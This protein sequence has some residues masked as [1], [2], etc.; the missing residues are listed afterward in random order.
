MRTITTSF[1]VYE[2]GELSK[3][4][5]RQASYSVS[6]EVLF[7]WE[8]EVYATA[9]ALVAHFHS[10]MYLDGVDFFQ[11][12]HYCLT[13]ESP[14]F[15]EEELAER[16]KALGSVDEDT[17]RGRGDCV[18]T[19]VCYD[20][21]VADVVRTGYNSGERDVEF[22]LRTAIHSL[23]KQA[24]EECESFYNNEEGVLQEFCDA[25]N[26]EFRESGQLYG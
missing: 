23:I 7:M 20:E 19:G 10:T 25:N 9:K 6:N 15:E 5:Q 24:R 13:I 11:D 18:L 16:I 21:D 12:H 1:D 22:L 4:A 14:E 3:E 17:G 26:M 2:F 8:D